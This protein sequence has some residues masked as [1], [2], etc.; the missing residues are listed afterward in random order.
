M[1]MPASVATSSIMPFNVA[2]ATAPSETIRA[3]YWN[4]R[5]EKMKCNN[6]RGTDAGKS[7][8]WTV[9]DGKTTAHLDGR[10]ALITDVRRRF[11][12]VVDVH[13]DEDVDLVHLSG[14]HATA[15][16]PDLFVTGGGDGGGEKI[17]VVVIVVERERGKKEEKLGGAG[18]G[19]GRGRRRMRR[20]GRRKA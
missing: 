10:E 9:A 13:G 6:C 16:T 12:V 1:G 2:E 19:G 18:E 20:S 17:L 14:H 11:V 7:E 3:Y 5:E 4:R 8:W 15:E